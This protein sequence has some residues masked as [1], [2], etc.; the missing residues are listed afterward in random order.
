MHERVDFDWLLCNYHLCKDIFVLQR[1]LLWHVLVPKGRWKAG[2]GKGI[3]ASI[4]T[5]IMVLHRLGFKTAVRD[6]A[7][8]EGRVKTLT[9]SSA[10]H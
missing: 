3:A 5:T 10:I 6:R 2:Q 9:R 4:I 1:R 7:K 8:Y